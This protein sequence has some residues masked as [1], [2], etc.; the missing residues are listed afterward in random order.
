MKGA[1]PLLSFHCEKA[2]IC[3][4]IGLYPGAGSLQ[5]RRGPPQRVQ[6]LSAGD[7]WYIYPEG[8]SCRYPPLSTGQF[9]RV[10]GHVVARYP[11]DILKRTKRD[12]ASFAAAKK[13]AAEGAPSTRGETGGDHTSKWH[14]T[15]RSFTRRLIDMKGFS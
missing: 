9:E 11:S 12:S 1:F 4:P 13:R 14:I 6:R 5:R 8:R 15:T 10:W 7:R 3:L 2:L